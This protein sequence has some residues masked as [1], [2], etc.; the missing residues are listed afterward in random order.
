M[1]Y[2][3]WPQLAAT[4]AS[5]VATEGSAAAAK[6]C[7]G[8]IE[9]EDY[10]AAFD[11][12]FGVIGADRL[13]EVLRASLV[14]TKSDGRLYRAI[15]RWPIAVYLTTNF[16]AEIPRHL[17]MLGQAYETYSNSRDH[18]SLLV[19]DLSGAVVRLHG[20][21]TSDVGLMLSKTQLH[22]LASG[23]GYDYW[24]TRMT[25]VFQME[26]V[27][28]LG[29]SLTDPHIRAVLETAKAGS[30]ATHPVCWISPDTTPSQAAEY[31]ER[32]RIRVIPYPAT[33]DHSGLFRTV[34]TIS[35]FV[36]PREGVGIRRAIAD[37]V[38][39]G[40]G[41]DPAATAIYVFNRLVPHVDLGTLRRDVALAALEAALP[42]LRARGTFSI[43]EVLG[44][45]GWPAEATDPHFLAELERRAVKKRLVTR[46]GS[47]LSVGPSTS[48]VDEHRGQ[49]QHLRN[50]FLTSVELRIRRDCSWIDQATAERLSR[51]IDAALTGFFKRGG[52]TLATI[53]VAAHK[54]RT[55]S[56]P[57]SIIG[58][59]S[60]ASAQYDAMPL[61]LAFWRGTL[62]AFTDAGD[63]ERQYLGRLAQGFLA[64]HAI[65][66]FGPAAEEQARIART[67]VW[68]VDS[69]L[70]IPAVALASPSNAAYVDVFG[71]LQSAKVRLFSTTKL[72]FETFAHFR[73]AQ[74]IVN[75]FGA[76]SHNALAAAIGDPPY[77][78]QNI[79]LQGYIQWQLAGH[80]GDWPAYLYAAVGSRDPAIAD[81]E[82]ALKRLG[83]EVI[84]FQDW[85]GFDPK[86][87]AEQEEFSERLKE[88]MRRHRSPD[89]ATDASYERRLE[90]KVPPEAEAAVVVLRERAGRFSIL[91]RA[92]S[93]SPAW[94]ISATAAI[95]ALDAAGP[96]T[97]QPEAFLAFVG[98]LVNT[99]GPSSDRAF[100]VII[101]GMAAS[102]LNPISEAAIEAAFGTVIDQ[103]DIDIGDQQ[104]AVVATLGDKYSERPADVLRRLPP[105]R[106]LLASLQL[107]KE[108]VERQRAQLEDAKRQTSAETRRAR[109]AEDELSA[110]GKLRK[111][112]AERQALALRRKRQSASRPTKKPKK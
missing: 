15:A 93:P 101:S 3:T 8:A 25:S 89:P 87:F 112:T 57:T 111:K 16:D 37:V 23:A 29:Y 66:V 56:V 49:F 84:D 44:E 99:A 69:S 26:R 9:N 78:K 108:L 83:L 35:Q 45:I 72:F 104:E 65:G 73:F 39:E 86:D 51:D 46:T 40:R 47:S 98:T 71:R 102:G 62:G 85:P 20:D 6:Q 90:D 41:E 58:F 36:V 94:F 48:A 95:N 50:R 81:L 11:V 30:R 103:A 88:L 4:A 28:V 19:S 64:F 110:V 63:A 24:R 53:L 80:P 92:G 76:D 67:T 17:A 18:M 82:A 106:R 79:F 5:L 2:P 59:I 22:E 14:P 38:A 27:V 77:W 97:W 21:L 55:I 75:R 105:S 12:A 43:E 10:P 109:K 70:Q 32:Y 91:P 42:R 68:L 13:L 31:S 1:G 100:E 60:E 54:K 74:D 34:E 107:S 61:R 52:L 7:H 96:I 33:T